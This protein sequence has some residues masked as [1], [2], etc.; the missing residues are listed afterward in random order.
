MRFL[1]LSLVMVAYA[2]APEEP[3]FSKNA[4]EI[5]SKIAAANRYDTACTGFASRPGEYCVAF[6]NLMKEIDPK[7]VFLLLK[8]KSPAI[9]A[10]AAHEVLE[11]K[12]V[13]QDE[14]LPL[15]KDEA[16]LTYFSGTMR[17]RVPLC[18]IVAEETCKRIENV[19]VQKLA[20]RALRENQISFYVAEELLGCMPVLPAR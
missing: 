13:P 10:Y 6:D 2:A 5:I 18:L 19:S 14:L 7:D 8:H 17:P 16:T 12:E 4:Q 15:L 9:R 1:F 3:V 20:T 11:L